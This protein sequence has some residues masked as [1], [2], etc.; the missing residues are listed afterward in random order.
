LGRTLNTAAYEQRN[1]E[2][3]AAPVGVEIRHLRYFLA[4][5][6]ELHFGRAAARLHIAQP[7]LSQAIRKL[8]QELGLQLLH[9]TSR[10]VTPTV[11][12]RVFADHARRVLAYLQVGVAETRRA[13]GLA[14]PLRI[15]CVPNLPIEHLLRFLDMVRRR[16]PDLPTE[17]IHIPATEQLRRLRDAELDVGVF[18]DIGGLDGLE[19]EPL[20]PG[21]PVAA[22]LAPRHR[23]AA[24]DVL[25]PAD[26]RDEPV[27]LFPRATNP[28]LHERLLHRIDE[29][30]YRLDELEEAGGPDTRDLL[31]AIAEGRGVALLPFSFLEA[32]EARALV[33]R[34]PLE[35]SVAWPDTV[36]AMRSDPPEQLRTVLEEIHAIARELHGPE[37][38]EAVSRS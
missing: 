30:G 25:G 7:P 1:D 31:L 3:A 21:E 5:Y 16:R 37:A 2:G 8:E 32:L 14:S 36:V 22:F 13:A 10:V 24:K 26:L 27:V 15:G 18:H 17:V 29:A 6:E 33:V 35:P 11:A 12:G 38:L 19:L 23:L 4:V 34:R 9:R 28:L 20:F